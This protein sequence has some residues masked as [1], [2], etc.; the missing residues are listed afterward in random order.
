MTASA[1]TDKVEFWFDPLCPWAW[2]TSRWMLEVQKVRPVEIEW[3]IMSLAYLNLV[4]HEGDGLSAEYRTL[5][6]KAWG[7]VRV[8][9]AAT[10][11]R[12][13]DILG[14]LYTAIGRRFHNEGRREDPHTINEALAEVGL[15]AALA[16]AAEDTSFDEAVR[17]SHHEAFD[18]VGLDVGTPVIRV[19]GH[20]FFGPVIS[21]APKGE[22][23]GRLFDAVRVVGATDGFF[24]FKRSRD[25]SPIFD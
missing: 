7:P 4:Q 14:P 1:Q 23:A 19:D 11:E 8:C 10:A 3:K 21:P 18:T 16:R 12:G 24:E 5:M 13:A 22:E 2:I 15:P 9:A 6:E 17:R 25:R 20:A